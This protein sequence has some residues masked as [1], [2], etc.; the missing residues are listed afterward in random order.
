MQQVYNWYVEFNRARD[1]FEDEPRT[2]RAKSAVISRS[3]EAVRQLIN[4]D[5]HINANRY[6]THCT[7]DRQQLNLFYMII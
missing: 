2:G 4:V 7:S 5:L 3:I 6:K 1:H